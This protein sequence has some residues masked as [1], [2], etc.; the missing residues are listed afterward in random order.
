MCRLSHHL[1]RLI[2]P[3]WLPSLDSRLAQ[4]S[5]QRRTS[6]CWTFHFKDN[7][8]KTSTCST[9]D[10]SIFIT[11][12][13]TYLNILYSSWFCWTNG[14]VGKTRAL[15]LSPEKSQL[16]CLATRKNC[17]GT[18]C[19]VP[20]LVCIYSTDWLPLCGYIILRTR[21]V[22]GKLTPHDPIATRDGA[23]AAPD[24][25]KTL[26]NAT[27]YILPNNMPHYHTK[28]THAVLVMNVEN[29]SVVQLLVFSVRP[30][31][32]SDP[33]ELKKAALPI[34]TLCQHGSDG[35]QVH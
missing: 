9:G 27:N 29:H 15:Q 13:N 18:N 30:R 14:K 26:H 31:K 22:R 11:V 19:P 21:G 23:C 33:L 7:V 3:V 34:G 25:T 4:H 17:W 35:T 20:V 12:R 32:K 1:Q 6:S 10:L 8:H 2:H 24:L 16:W 28:I 5:L